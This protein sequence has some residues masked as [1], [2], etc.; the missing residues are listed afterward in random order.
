MRFARFKTYV[1]SRFIKTLMDI[2]EDKETQ[3]WVNLVTLKLLYSLLF[4]GVVEW[5]YVWWADNTLSAMSEPLI[6]NE[7][8]LLSLLIHYPQYLLRGIEGGLSAVLLLNLLMC[9]WISL[10]RRLHRRMTPSDS[11]KDGVSHV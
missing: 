8:F 10:A 2:D 9:G 7:Q 4:F 11:V 6:R 5:V 1:H 3:K